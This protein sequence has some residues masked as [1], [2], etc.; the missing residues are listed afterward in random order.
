MTLVKPRKVVWTMRDFINTASD[1]EHIIE[2]DFDGEKY[3]NVVTAKRTAKFV[4]S[5][6]FK[7]YVCDPLWAELESHI[8]IYYNIDDLWDWTMKD[9]R[10]DFVSRCPMAKGFANVTL[11]LLHELGHSETGILWKE[12]TDTNNKLVDRFK[13]GEIDKH[14]LQFAYFRFPDETAATDWAIE[15]LK[16][17]EHRKIAKKFEKEFF[18]CFK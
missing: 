11:T 1:L 4:K 18:K 6:H 12:R 8:T 10:K 5:D 16:D 7:T 14:E 15:W 2:G 13:N 9:F 3:T 17:A